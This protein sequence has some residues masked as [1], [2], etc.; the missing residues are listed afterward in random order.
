MEGK[1]QN[2]NQVNS[3]VGH[4]YP[5]FYSF[6]CSWVHGLNTPSEWV[7]TTHRHHRS[8][9]RSPSQVPRGAASRG[10]LS[11]EEML[12]GNPGERRLRSGRHRG[13]TATTPCATIHGLHP[14]SSSKTADLALHLSALFMSVLSRDEA[15][16]R[17]MDTRLLPTTCLWSLWLR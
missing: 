12:L 7:F 3:N 8:E 5:L 1:N 16:F 11:L 15:A 9:W 2:A 10:A 4:V 17:Y 14:S 6:Q 13:G